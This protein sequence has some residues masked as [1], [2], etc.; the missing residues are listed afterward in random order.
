MEKHVNNK[1]YYRLLVMIVLYFALM[2]FLMYAMVNK[3]DNIVNNYNQIY[4][5]SLMTLPMVILE[6]TLMEGMYHK[7]ILNFLVIGVSVVIFVLSFVFIRQ[8]TAISDKQF[9]RSMIP[10][11]AAAILMCE[12]AKI[13]YPELAEMVKT[14]L[15]NYQSDIEQMKVMLAEMEK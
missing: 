14:M 12:Q 7:K 11:D 4:M 13:D 5:A 1:F 8:Q 10:H 6:L 2:Y 15:Q 9:L 3:F